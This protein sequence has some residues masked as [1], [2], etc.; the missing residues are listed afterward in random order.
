MRFLQTL[1]FPWIHLMGVDSTSPEIAIRSENQDQ[2]PLVP[3]RLDSI[4]GQAVIEGVMMRSPKRLAVAV[5]APN[6]EIVLDN[7]TFIPYTRRH[8]VLSWPILRGAASL[9]ESLAMGMRALNFS[10]AVQEKGAAR[11]AAAHPEASRAQG[12]TSVTSLAVSEASDNAEG[13]ESPF[14]KPASAKDKLLIAASLGVSFLFAMALFQFLPYF[15]SGHLVGGSKLDNPNPILFN[16]VAGA[17]RISL[18]LVYLAFIS[19]LP[20]VARVFQY[21]GAEHKS[22]FAHEHRQ[23][24][25]SEMAGRESRFHP[26][27]GTSFR[28]TATCFCTAGSGW[29]F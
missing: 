5:R 4:G 1:H 7:R 3:G 12:N 14:S 23:A 2:E 9:I 15:A 10:I 16:T 24:L 8:W 17:V 11:Q 20:D 29:W 13:S 22:I 19:R 6:G 21:H 27:C 18:L 28:A 25:T 26:R